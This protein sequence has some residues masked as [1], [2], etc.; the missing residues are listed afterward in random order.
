VTDREEHMGY[1]LLSAQDQVDI[2]RQRIR[3]LE[4]DHFLACLV[5]RENPEDSVARRDAD[6][7]GRRIRLHLNELASPAESA[8]DTV[9]SDGMRP[10]EGDDRMT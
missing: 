7:L 6:E 10:P 9:E 8:K 5:L 3:S 2:R 4:A 1:A